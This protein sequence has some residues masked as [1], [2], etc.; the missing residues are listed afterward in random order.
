LIPGVLLRDPVRSTQFGAALETDF[1]KAEGTFTFG[2]DAGYASGDPSP[3]FGVVQRPGAPAPKAGDLDGPQ[4]YPPRD[5]RADNFRF[6]PDYR[7]DRILFREII[8]AVTDAAYLKPHARWLMLKSPAFDVALSASAVASM[9]MYASSTPG[10]KRP[11]GV[12]LDPSLTY[13][14]RDGFSLALD[15]A[16]LFPLA[17]LDGLEQ[18]GVKAL[19]AKPAQLLRARIGFSF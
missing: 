8:G 11:L 16:V 10:G 7:I 2:F 12:E 18:P 14:H 13:R 5:R 15:Y 4:A 17:G 3:G 6:H 1:G 9:A 19:A